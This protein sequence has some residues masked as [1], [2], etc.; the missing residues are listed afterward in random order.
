METLLVITH[1]DKLGESLAKGLSPEGTEGVY[2]SEIR[3]I[4]PT[5][6]TRETQD[7]VFAVI[8]EASPDIREIVAEIKEVEAFIKREIKKVMVFRQNTT[9]ETN[10]KTFESNTQA[11]GID[12]LL[13]IPITLVTVRNWLA[14][15]T[16]T[17]P[18]DTI[19]TDLTD[20]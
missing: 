8:I 3:E 18:A 13:G 10:L 2:I 20:D 15:F 1:D 14:K 9:A 19:K 11:L 6:I 16:K 7:Q 17:R 12:L 4:A 5:I